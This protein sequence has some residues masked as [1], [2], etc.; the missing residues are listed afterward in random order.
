[1]RGRSWIPERGSTLEDIR[2]PRVRWTGT[3]IECYSA[4][5]RATETSFRR[6]VESQK[7]ILRLGRIL[8]ASQKRLD[9]SQISSSLS[10]M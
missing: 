6:T 8:K 5:G 4:K 7:K 1:M 3:L 9:G 10:I 2:R